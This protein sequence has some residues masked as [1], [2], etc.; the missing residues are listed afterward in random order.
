[1]QGTKYR[2]SLLRKVRLL[3]PFVS[4]SRTRSFMFISYELEHQLSPGAVCSVLAPARRC[5]PTSHFVPKPPLLSTEP[6]QIDLKAPD[7]LDA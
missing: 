7:D 1:M 5:G 2:K 3:R 4:Q 6:Q